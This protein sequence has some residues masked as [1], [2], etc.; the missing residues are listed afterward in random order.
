MLKPCYFGSEVLAPGVNAVGL[1]VMKK[2]HASSSIVLAAL[3]LGRYP[4]LWDRP[5]AGDVWCDSSRTWPWRKSVTHP[6]RLETRTKESNMSAS[7]WVAKPKG[8][9][10]VKV[11]SVG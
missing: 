2:V 5:C 6:T 9:M 10:R 8:A 3:V 1:T 11:Y 7:H 4:G